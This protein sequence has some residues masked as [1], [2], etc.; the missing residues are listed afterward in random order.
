MAAVVAV[1][2]FLLALDPGG[3]EPLTRE[4]YGAKLVAALARFRALHAD[5][6]AFVAAGEGTVA[7]G[8]RVEVELL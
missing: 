3:D 1:A 5:A 7:A 4:Q 6:L 8:E 2:V